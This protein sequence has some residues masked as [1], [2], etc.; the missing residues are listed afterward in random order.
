MIIVHDMYNV[1]LRNANEIILQ[2]KTQFSQRNVWPLN[3]KRFYLKLQYKKQRIFDTFRE[4]ISILVLLARIDVEPVLSSE[5][6]KRTRRTTS[7]PRRRFGLGK[8]DL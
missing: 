1:G 6:G 5:Q 8:Q 7:H 2:C 3:R 4:N